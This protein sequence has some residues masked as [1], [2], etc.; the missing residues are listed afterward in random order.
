MTPSGALMFSHTFNERWAIGTGVYG[1]G[2]AGMK[3]ENVRFPDYVGGPLESNSEMTIA[4]AALGLAYKPT[5]DLSLGLALRATYYQAEV[6]TPTRAYS[7]AVIANPIFK[8]LKGTDAKGFK[9]GLQYEFNKNHKLGV[10]YRSESAAILDGKLES[11]KILTPALATDM[12]SGE[13]ALKLTLP[14]SVTLGMAHR[15]SQRWSMSWEYCWLQYSKMAEFTLSSSNPLV[16]T[17][18]QKLD[19]KDAHVLRLGWEYNSKFPVRFGFNYAT[20]VTDTLLAGVGLPPAPLYGVSLGTGWNFKTW[21]LD[22]ALDGATASATG[23]MSAAGD[24]TSD[25]RYGGYSFWLMGLHTS[26]R[27][28]F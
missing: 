26:L 6:T 27:W 3:Y 14:Q 4:E 25:S 17:Q 5:P 8:D 2:G 10:N 16:G 21:S 23:G 22:V 7:G 13:A 12:G 28:D 24:I 18:S 9:F 15:L 20:Q 1:V 11:G 19:W